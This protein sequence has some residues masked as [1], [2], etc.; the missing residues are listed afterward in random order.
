MIATAAALFCAA[1]LSILI[2]A[3]QAANLT[4][5]LANAS[6]AWTVLAPTDAAF[7]AV[8][9]PLNITAAELLEETVSKEHTPPLRP[10]V[11]GSL[12]RHPGSPVRWLRC[13]RCPRHGAIFIETWWSAGAPRAAQQ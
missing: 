11:N 6:T 4:A 9:R 12:N 1:N 7:E 8:L 3:V 10:C 2:A 13:V 5:P